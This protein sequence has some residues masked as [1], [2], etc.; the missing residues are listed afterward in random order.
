[1]GKGYYYNSDYFEDKY[2]K[3]IDTMTKQAD[4]YIAQKYGITPPSE[5][6]DNE[7][8]ICTTNEFKQISTESIVDHYITWEHTNT[9]LL[10]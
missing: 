4:N 10:D 7:T 5:D 6:N 9:E 1:M 8:P 3:F 2:Q